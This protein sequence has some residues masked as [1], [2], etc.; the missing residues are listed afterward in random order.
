M[1][2]PIKRNS[3]LP[4]Q[5]PWVKVPTHDLDESGSIQRCWLC[6]H[7]L[8]FGS[9][10]LGG[11]GGAVEVPPQASGLVREKAPGLIGVGQGPQSLSGIH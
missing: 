9:D 10:F 11:G 1:K 2:Y 3:T 6:A 5:A 8:R 7:K 4:P